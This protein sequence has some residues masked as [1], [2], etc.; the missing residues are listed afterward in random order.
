MRPRV[1]LSIWSRSGGAK[2]YAFW[3]YGNAMNAL[4]KLYCSHPTYLK[5][6][7]MDQSIGLK[8]KLH[9]THCQTHFEKK[10]GG[11][12]GEKKA[13]IYTDGKK[14]S[15]ALFEISLRRRDFLHGGARERKGGGSR[16][17]QPITSPDVEPQDWGGGSANVI[18]FKSW[19]QQEPAFW[20]LCS[21]YT[22]EIRVLC[23]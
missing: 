12:K 22:K 6:Y 4:P 18:Q 16:L 15:Q 10:S 13:Y 7:G 11:P 20:G 19:A 1:S 17:A 3:V 2:S 9:H 8:W 21:V 5:K 14:E 23:H